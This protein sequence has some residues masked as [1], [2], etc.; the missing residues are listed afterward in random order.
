MVLHFNEKTFINIIFILSLLCAWFENTGHNKYKSGW[1]D[2]INLHDLTDSTSEKPVIHSH[3][4]GFTLSIKHPA[5]PY[6]QPGKHMHM[7]MLDCTT[8]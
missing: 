1:T 7:Q 2:K 4:Y 8:I 6:R 5:Q 3:T